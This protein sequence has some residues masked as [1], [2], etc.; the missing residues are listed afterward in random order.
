VGGVVAEDDRRVGKLDGVHGRLKGGVGEVDRHAQVVH[1]PDHRDPKVAETA[2][3]A[4]VLAI[5]DIIL[6]GVGQAGQPD[7]H[8]G[9]NVHAVE[10]L[11]DG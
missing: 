11:A 10:F 3:M 2:V 7:A 1:A 8:M 5:T 9:E 4:L 6:A